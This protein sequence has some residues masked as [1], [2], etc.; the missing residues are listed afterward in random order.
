MPDRTGPEFCSAPNIYGGLQTRK[1]ELSM[2]PPRSRGP[3]LLA[4][5]ATLLLLTAWA[6][7][8]PP[9]SNPTG[10]P[11]P[12]GLALH[13]PPLVI[14]LAPL[15]DL[16][17]GTSM[18][19]MSR[20]TGWL[21]GILLLYLAWR[22]IAW[23]GRRRRKTH[24]PWWERAGRE[25]LVAVFALV[26]LV[27]FLAAGAL[28][29]RPMVSLA[30]AGPDRMVVDLHS[31]TNASHDVKH[32]LMGGFDA[33][34][35]QRWHRRAGFDAAFITDH[36]TVEGLPPAGADTMLP[37]LCPGTEVSG[38]RA[39]IVLLGTRQRMERSPYA[40]SLAGLLTLFPDARRA[41]AVSIASLPE[42]SRNHWENLDRFVRAGVDGFEIV[43]ASPKASE[44]T[45]ARRDSVIALARENDL[46]VV[47]VS[48]SHGWGA[49]SMAWNLVSLPRWR[50]ATTAPCHI[51][52]QRLRKGGFD[53]VQVVERHH[54][55]P[56]DWWP[57]WLTPVGM[58]WETWRAMD[59]RHLLAWLAWIWIVAGL[60]IRWTAVRPRR[61]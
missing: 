33:A 1:G 24:S 46:M 53:A 23:A 48:D 25:V 50:Q 28:W 3:F 31:H 5:A 36:N 32:T 18:L 12:E 13:S 27:A 34:A 45:R 40:D 37:A 11:L 57:A 59:W 21:A 47:G 38:W 35:L 26:G 44:F 61:G 4:T 29:H 8:V 9:L 22:L 52:L 56:D 20:L 6:T 54:L 10:L 15:F 42:Y 51:L 55:R 43:N 19:S 16:W 41:G 60:R 30:G 49:T 14:L 2:P 17:D 58:V 7:G 39:H